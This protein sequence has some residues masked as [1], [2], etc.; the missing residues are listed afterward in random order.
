MHQT[1][2]IGLQLSHNDPFW[3]L[4]RDAIYQRSLERD[5]DLIPLELDLTQFSGEEQM[6]LVEELLAQELDSLIAHSISPT[7]LQTILETNVPVI[8]VAE[9]ELNHPLATAPKG[10]YE[11]A[12]MLASFLAERLQGQGQV[13]L[14]GGYAKGADSGLT[15][16]KGSNDVFHQHPGIH[17]T[18]IPSP[19][20]RAGTY[21]VVQE[22]LSQAP[23]RP[24][25]ILGISDSLALAARDVCNDLGLAR[26]GLL[27][28]GINGDPLALAA[29]IQGAMTA[30][31]ETPADKLGRQAVDLAIQVAQ[32]QPLPAHFSYHP[33]LVALDNVA[34]VAAEKLV[35]IAD[36]PSHQVGINHRQE[37]ERLTQL[38]TS[39]A[40]SQRVGSIL[41]RQELRHEIANL[42]RA[43]Y[44]YDNVQIF[45]W[46]EANKEFVLDTPGETEEDLHRIPLAESSLLGYTLLHN[47][48]TFIPDMHHSQR[49]QPDPYWP[50]T[51]SRV[52]LPVRL[53]G[54]ML[55]LLDLHSQHTTQHTYQDLIGLQSLADQLGITMRNAQLYSEALAARR[56]AEQANRLKSRLL[57]NVSHALR[58]PLNV[59]Q[60]YSQAALAT[61]SPYGIDLPADLLRDLRHIATSSQH[62]TRL[63]NDLLDLSRAETSQLDIFPEPIKTRPFLQE[64]FESMAGSRGGNPAIEWRLELPA[65]LPVIEA[66]PLRLRQILLNLL[67]N[68]CKFS[69]RGHISLSAQAGPDHLHIRVE[70]TGCGIPS[71]R[72]QHIFEAFATAEQPRQPHQGIG[73]GLRIAYELVKLHRG[74]IDL[75]SIPGAGSIVHIR[76]PL[77]A[78]RQQP[79]APPTLAPLPDPDEA[80]PAHLSRLTRQSAAYLRQ[81]FDRPLS[82]RELAGELGVNEHYL[83]RVFRRELGLTPWQ[84]LTRHRIRQAQRLLRS[85][86]A[87]VTEI[88][89]QVGY[90]D[91]AYFSRVFR[92][93]TGQSPRAFRRATAG[94][95]AA[96]TDERK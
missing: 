29:I 50:Q 61:P 67:S 20:T 77:K 34:E 49:F 90:N 12:Y 17:V 52:I 33:R 85:S 37:Q 36:L 57:A 31:V 18:H 84:Y 47:Q 55:G 38:E 41:D 21:D 65:A 73:L 56:E 68:A 16:I 93:E 25:A 3:V 70:D 15:R 2:R 58:T 13:L 7:V 66:D 40:I 23:L 71:E 11:V 86:H 32:G 53:G 94:I 5:V 46:Q 82:R 8:S 43:N 91:A 54:A 81:H 78:A 39:L 76:L 4:A 27:V 83:S 89:S 60:G 44:G 92:K 10:L 96:G 80:L 79:A 75:Q 62:L 74:A 14:V 51:R 30:T 42:I 63:I 59:I 69:E 9:L 24:D 19:W 87:T 95:R 26:P 6:A 88:A 35:A 28:G 48:P 1:I 72:Q 64:V 45:L 22:Q